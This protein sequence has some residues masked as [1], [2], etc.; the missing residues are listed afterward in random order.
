V[1]GGPDVNVPVVTPDHVVKI[2]LIRA[3]RCCHGPFRHQVVQPVLQGYPATGLVQAFSLVSTRCWAFF[4]VA[5]LRF[6]F[7]TT[8]A[9]VT[10]FIPQRGL[11]VKTVL[12]GF[13]VVVEIRWIVTV[14]G[15]NVNL[16]TT[17]ADGI[18]RSRFTFHN[19]VDHG[20]FFSD[21]KAQHGILEEIPQ[22][23]ILSGHCRH[24]TLE[25]AQDR[26]ARVTVAPSIQNQIVIV[27]FVLVFK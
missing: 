6:P 11:D 23:H 14:L 19:R 12:T 10:G 3:I 1:T 21:G 24:L 25:D 8:K 22:D 5:I 7:I 16:V 18:S 4:H 13:Y 9:T 2:I 17:R 26:C 15:A 27:G 20:A